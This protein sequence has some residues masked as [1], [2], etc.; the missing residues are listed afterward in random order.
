MENTPWFPLAEGL[1][2]ICELLA[3]HQKPSSDHSKIYRKL[4]E[5]SASPE[6]NNYL[7]YLF[8][9]GGQ[10][11]PLDVRQ[12]AGLLLK[13]KLKTQFTSLPDSNR[14]YIQSSVVKALSSNSS[15]LRQTA[16]VLV[17]TLISLEDSVLQWTPLLQY[18]KDALTGS[19]KISKSAA[20]DSL[21]KVSEDSPEIFEACFLNEG[22]PSPGVELVYL[23]L[24]Q[25]TNQS[26]E[27]KRFG[28]MIMNLLL[29]LIPPPPPSPTTWT[30]LLEI[31]Q[32]SLIQLMSNNTD[33][34]IQKEVC[35]GL[36]QFLTFHEGVL[37]PFM[38]VV[39][40]H[41]LQFS[42]HPDCE[43]ALEAT[44]FW[45]AFLDSSVEPIRLRTVLKQLIPILL[46]NM[47][48]REDDEAVISMRQA[49]SN[50]PD[51][52]S[53]IRPFHGTNDHDEDEEEITGSWTLRKCSAAGIDKLSL[54]FG[55]ELLSEILPL[56]D[57]KLA[58]PDWKVRES[59][60]LVLGAISEGCKQGL[61]P[62]LDQVLAYVLD[63][64][65]A[66]RI[67]TRT[68]SNDKTNLIFNT[69]Y[70]CLEDGNKQVQK[71]SCS[72]LAT[73]VEIG[74]EVIHSHAPFILRNLAGVCW[75]YGRKNLRF[76]YDAI[77]T[78][79]ENAPQSLSIASER[80][81]LL[82]PL[83]SQFEKVPDCDKTLPALFSCLGAIIGV[84]GHGLDEVI[85][86]IFN[87]C[88]LLIS[89]GHEE[90]ATVASLDLISSL[91]EA[92]GSDLD[93]LFAQSNL[94]ELLLESSRSTTESDIKQ[95][96][97][98]LVGELAK[99]LP[100]QMKRFLKSF[101]ELLVDSFS[102]ESI[103]E[104]SLSACNNG[105]W[106]LGELALISTEFQLQ[107]ISHRALEHCVNLII[108]SQKLPRIF[109][110]NVA[111]TLGRLSLHCAHNFAQFLQSFLAPWC[112]LLRNV[113]DDNEKEQ[114]FIGLFKTVR[115]NPAAAAD[116]FPSLCAAVA[117][118][119]FG[120]SVQLK[121]EINSVL[122]SLK[123][124]LEA[125]GEWN[126]MWNQVPSQIRE[127][128]DKPGVLSD[129]Y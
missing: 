101:L 115:A 127:K 45:T 66:E 22:H 55:D 110:E 123:Q 88:L 124:D 20:L 7:V 13:N 70:K 79:A 39:F 71:S 104:S 10:E 9:E 36:S 33:L 32:Q 107:F 120:M 18:L 11:F 1:H 87:K 60:I 67:I 89:N 98:A 128:L 2:G 38:E 62:H 27:I 42:V 6:F 26:S 76:V 99:K 16:S 105:C 75:K 92:L 91:L 15:V 116:N 21:L 63:N 83:L 8:A 46:D 14:Q 121:Q 72:A 118:W 112:E 113:R 84:C 69:L 51:L 96:A 12:S 108:N 73:I 53:E 85:P 103:T 48:Y 106:A 37:S 114:A 28:L 57:V 109:G 17:S 47:V 49:E 125:R 24:Q 126:H 78:L 35:Y 52:D 64:R 97:F 34:S 3:E 58:S 65:Y 68:K 77:S 95:S 25:L 59:G 86:M 80:V 111:I 44:E 40:Q 102:P 4:E 43:I 41:M 81:I 50:K 54:I 100:E 122:Q 90:D 74:G 61:D 129:D 82:T 23:V 29:P 93:P 119:S 19:D 31:Y 30:Q 56:I 117:S 94:L 5:Y